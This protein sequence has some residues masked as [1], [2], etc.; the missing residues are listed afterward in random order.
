MPISLPPL[1]RLLGIAVLALALA[2]CGSR[3]DEENFA[4]I[5][6]GMSQQEVE[7]I[8]GKP[9]EA[10]SASFG[11]LSGGSA[12]WTHKDV[13]ISIQFMNDKVQFKQFLRGSPQD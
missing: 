10:S 12:S 8:L 2:A 9:S 11:G 3:I 7:A 1:T 6:T 4:R 5:E 13:T